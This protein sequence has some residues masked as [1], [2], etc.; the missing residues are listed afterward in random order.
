MSILFISDV[1][2]CVKSSYITNGFLC[3][4]KNY[5]IRAKALYILGDLFDAWLGDDD[6]NPLHINIAKA[7]KALHRK[8]ISCY[9]IHGNHDFL[10]GKKYA[11]AC[12]MKLLSSKQVLQLESGKKIIIL[13]GDILCS[14]DGSYQLF[15]K[16]LRHIIAQRLFLSL[17]LSVRSRIFSSMRACCTQHAKY[18]STKQLDINLKTATDILIQNNADIMIHGHTHQPATHNIYRSRSKKD[19]LKIIVLGCWN[20][21]GSIVEINEKNNDILFTEFP[22]Y[23]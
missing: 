20:K 15:R 4:L 21:Y 5:A 18:K 6:C 17:P 16:C 14:N 11:S 8:R 22:L 3:F 23:K 9:F 12:G 13:H 1:H 19:I 7:L 10:L 2:L